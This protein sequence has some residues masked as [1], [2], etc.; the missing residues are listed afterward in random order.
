[1]D[2]HSST[3]ILGID[4]VGRGP[5]AGPVTVGVVAFQRKYNAE[6]FKDAR[7]SKKLSPKKREYFYSLLESEREKGNVQYAV[8]SVVSEVIDEK[9]IV[10]AIRSALSSALISLALD[11]CKCEVLLDGNL[12]AP[13]V[14]TNQ[15]TI[16]GGDDKEISIM[17][18]S[19]AAKVL[20]DREMTELDEKYPG[21]LFAKH[22]GYG[23]AQH[24]EALRKL[25]LCD[26]HRRSFLGNFL[27][28]D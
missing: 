4:E 18:A 24:Y 17:L 10:F 9:G 13:P 12:F 14:Y 16:V 21:Y 20:R 8:H 11:P 5:I 7:D 2:D 15:R 27:K 22:K 28:A 3:Y 19:I 1:M 25:G 6:V 23:T 26:I